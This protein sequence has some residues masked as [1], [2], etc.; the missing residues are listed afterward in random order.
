MANWLQKILLPAADMLPKN[1]NL[2]TVQRGGQLPASTGL[3]H[4]KLPNASVIYGAAAGAMFVMSVYLIF[5]SHWF[6]GLLVALPGLALLGFA[7]HFL[8]R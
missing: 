3:P 7:L 5:T 6:T 8:K 4:A 1:R 2:P